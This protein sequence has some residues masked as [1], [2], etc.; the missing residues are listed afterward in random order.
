M[1]PPC[2]LEGA[3]SEREGAPHDARGRA[4]AA[5]TPPRPSQVRLR[6][7]EPKRAC[8]VRVIRRAAEPASI[9]AMYGDDEEAREAARK[10]VLLREKN[11]SRS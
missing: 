7:Q 10:A 9:R 5:P 6:E 11:V 1:R 4:C 8:A 3:R 2:A